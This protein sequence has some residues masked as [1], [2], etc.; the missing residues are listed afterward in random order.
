MHT[1]IQKIVQ[2]GD[3]QSQKLPKLQIL[4]K[5]PFWIFFKNFFWKIHLFCI[6]RN[7]LFDK[8]FV[9]Q[10]SNFSDHTSV[11]ALQPR[12][13][14]PIITL[15]LIWNLAIFTVISIL[16]FFKSSSSQTFLKNKKIIGTKNSCFLPLYCFSFNKCLT[17]QALKKVQYGFHGKNGKVSDQTERT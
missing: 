12:V 16:K 17:T 10:L 8:I 6:L 4:K 1:L 14:F 13:V 5:S 15:C 3:A 7:L 9:W 11:H 2:N